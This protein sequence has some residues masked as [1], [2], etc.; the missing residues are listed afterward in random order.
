MFTDVCFKTNVFLHQMQAKTCEILM[1]IYDTNH[2]GIP[3]Q[4]FL[5]LL[6]IFHIIFV[7][8]YFQDHL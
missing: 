2:R 1:N 5:F 6:N 3:L 8:D 4:I 7:K